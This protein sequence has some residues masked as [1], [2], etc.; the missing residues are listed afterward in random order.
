MK[1][2]IKIGVITLSLISAFALTSK[3]QDS[4]PAASNTG[5]G[6]RLSIG[7]DAGL[8]TGS[9]H[10]RYD[11]SIGGS[12]QADFPIVKDELNVIVN[13]GY[14]D[15]FA[16]KGVA[17]AKD[18]QMIPVKAGL[19]FFPVHAF[20]IQGEAGASFLTNKKDVGATKS[21]T[22]VYAPQIGYLIPLGGKNAIDAGIRWE[23]NTKFVDGGST[24]NFF[25]LRVAYSFGL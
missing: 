8:P 9:F 10:N 19:K 5:S 17:D 16:K 20:Y 25:A 18:L 4:K 1:N 15:F 23:S 3:A 7:P 11:W 13:A 22:F 24:N 14:N 6:I 2:S 21:T 12:I